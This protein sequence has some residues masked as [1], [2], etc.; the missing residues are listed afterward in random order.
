MLLHVLSTLSDTPSSRIPT[1][2]QLSSLAG[3]V[4]LMYIAAAASCMST[5]HEHAYSGIFTYL[6]PTV[7]QLMLPMTSSDSHLKHSIP[8]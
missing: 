6:Q 1:S 8:T 7:K 5:L 4:C 3:T 2:S